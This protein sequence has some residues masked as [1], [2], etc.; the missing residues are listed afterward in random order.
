MNWS[1]GLR[2]VGVGLGAAVALWGVLPLFTGRLHVGNAVLMLIGG[3]VV[4]ICLTC[5]YSIPESRVLTDSFAKY[6]QTMENG[7]LHVFLLL[8][9]LQHA[10]LV[11]T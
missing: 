1:M 10:I 8:L 2:A 9:R 6:E 7:F 5:Q 11:C 4:L 3:L